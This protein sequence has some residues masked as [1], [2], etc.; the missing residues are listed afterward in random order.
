MKT[1][2][3]GVDQV[4]FEEKYTSGYL[5]VCSGDKASPLR[6]EN[7]DGEEVVLE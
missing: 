7:G 4:K 5:T 3:I 6:K 2:S 1:A